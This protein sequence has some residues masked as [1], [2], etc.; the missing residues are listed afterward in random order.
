MKGTGASFITS[1]I[2][3]GVWENARDSEKGPSF[4]SFLQ[5]F[6][7]FRV[8]AYPFNTAYRRFVSQVIS[9]PI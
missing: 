8:L 6:L 9:M 4:F 1:G 2:A 3:T 5:S 7:V